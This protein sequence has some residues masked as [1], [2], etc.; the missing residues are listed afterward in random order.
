MA[1]NP[2]KDESA[3]S[4]PAITLSLKKPIKPREG[5]VVTLTGPTGNSKTMKSPG[6]KSLALF[7]LVAKAYSLAKNRW[8]PSAPVPILAGRSGSPAVSLELTRCVKVD[9]SGLGYLRELFGDDYNNPYKKGFLAGLIYTDNPGFGKKDQPV[10][11]SY[12]PTAFPIELVQVLWEGTSQ[13]INDS[14]ELIDIAHEILGSE[15]QWPPPPQFILEPPAKPPAEASP[16]PS[17]TEKEPPPV[18]AGA[19]PAAEPGVSPSGTGSRPATQQEPAHPGPASKKTIVQTGSGAIAVGH[20]AMAAGKGSVVVRGSVQGSTIITGDGNVIQSAAA[21]PGSHET[22]QLPSASEVSQALTDYRRLLV[23]SCSRLPLRGIDI[24]ASD[25]TVRQQQLHLDQVY[26]NLDTQTQVQ[27]EDKEQPRPLQEAFAPDREKS[28]PLSA[29]EAAA[30]NRCVVLLGDPGSG[31]ST[32][33][34][35]LT[36]CLAL[37]DL[38][39][40]NQWLRHLPGWPGHEGSLLPIPVVLR[41]F[42]GSLGD[43]PAQ[44]HVRHLWDFIAKRLREQK[45]ESAERAL[46]EALQDGRALVLLDGLDELPTAAQRAF[47]RDAVA[48]FA[49]RY[50]RSRFIVTCRTLSY[51]DPAWQLP[52][53]F[54]AF[55]LAPFSPEKIDQFINAWYADLERVNV[56]K[57]EESK[58]LAGRLHEA[59]RQP[60]LWRLAP[61]PLLLTVMA[62]VHTHKGRLPDAR[63][64]L[65]EETVDILL[66]RWEQMKLGGPAETAGLRQLLRQT[67]RSDV[68]L[69]RRLYRLAFEAH[70]AGGA[71]P[72]D[73]LADISESALESTLAELHPQRSLDWAKELI[74]TI[75]LRAGLLLERVPQV[76]TFPHRTFQEYL[77]GAHLATQANFATEATRLVGEGAFWREV[78]L[79]AVGKL[80]YLNEDIDKPVALAAALCPETALRSDLGW[81]K[82]WL[83]GDVLNEITLPR[84]KES[85]LGPE[86]LHRVK[87]RLAGLL[88]TGALTPV[89]RA[90]A[91]AALG[92]LG[93]PRPGVGVSSKGWPD[94]EWIEI[95]SGPFVMG[96]ETDVVSWSKETPQFRC[97]LITRPYR[98]SRYPVTVAQFD[99]FVA[100]RGYE[101]EKYWTKAGWDWRQR[102]RATRPE[103]YQ[104]VYQTRNHPRVG[105]SWYEALAYCLWLSQQLG[106]MITLP[107]EAEWERAARHTDGRTFPWGNEDEAPQRCNMADTGIGH[108]SAVGLFPSGNAVCGASDM[109]GNVWEWTRSLWG[110]DWEKPAFGY[111][112]QPQDGRENLEAPIE[113]RRVLRGGSWSSGRGDVR[114][115][116]R[117]GFD[118]GNRNG[119][120]GFRVVASPFVSGR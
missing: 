43:T 85:A 25:P 37:N 40:A 16:L 80:V 5:P 39:P 41:D 119:D 100:A 34:N 11:L 76:Y 54:R 112:Y 74:V 21:Q 96:S 29:L 28:R 45:L 59:I 2:A 91:G 58:P 87:K 44:A 48:A 47:V 56:V 19:P 103:N 18:A 13:P 57:T 67:N 52:E 81:R 75:K 78:L 64:V 15:T 77:A 116:Y 66:W 55:T 17:R 35:H 63:A 7:F 84:V 9:G 109:G 107:S 6:F 113:V 95:P 62:L 1:T 33:L 60:D 117:N 42:I 86:V 79:L 105:V 111:P 102:S 93:D 10:T 61:N 108:T 99:C 114:C 14:K 71:G 110:K 90:A 97:E 115:A 83:A 4:R 31:K 72:G 73:A 65:Y 120:F 50:S 12:N 101:E 98:I 46:P 82:V 22:H 94:I 38:E 23:S 51:Q 26:V 88:E 30:Q 70:R 53:D 32:F 69:K 104:E 20:G 68:D 24:A 92:K 89:E 106:F 3:S 49:A 8:N 36:L 118:P 27:V